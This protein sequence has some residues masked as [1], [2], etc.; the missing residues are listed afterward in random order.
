MTCIRRG[1]SRNTDARLA[2]AELYAAIAQPE[3]ALVLFFCSCR[4]DL[5][6][7]GAELN[8]LFGETPLMGCTTAGEIGPSGLSDDML[9]GASFSAKEFFAISGGVGDLKEFDRSKGH[10]LCQ[11]LLQRLW[12]QDR[13]SVAQ[14]S[15]AIL[16]VD[17]LSLREEIVARSI[18]DV[19][20]EI[21]LVGGSASCQPESCVT[22]IYA[23]GHFQSD[24]ATLTLVTTNLPFR[25]DKAQHFTPTEERV[26]ITEAD[27]SRRIVYEINGR[28]AAEE[29]ARL[30]G[31]QAS[32]LTT[33][34]IAR[35]PL[36][37]LLN[38]SVYVRGVQ[39]VNADGSLTFFCAIERGVVLRL[40]HSGDLI[41]NLQAVFDEIRSDIGR[42]LATIGFDC[43]LRR[44]EIEQEKLEDS[45]A[46][47]LVDNNAI[48][49]CTF[50]EQYYGTHINQT[51]VC[52]AIGEPQ[53]EARHG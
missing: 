5:E 8:R 28:P 52:I 3:M 14:H 48:G 42:P 43:M 18:Q 39:R 20:S 49:F 41:G 23:D 53:R 51:F 36:A 15:F 50:G 25:V 44:M 30:L 17:G 11:G 1:C 27:P 19:L 22:K 35:S 16:L 46:A 2:A 13:F 33:E 21:P 6:V 45:V 31:A 38:G 4:Y 47:L 37:V 29:Y 7:L 40:A 10:T 34:L 24:L 32:G 26:V 12:L 9:V